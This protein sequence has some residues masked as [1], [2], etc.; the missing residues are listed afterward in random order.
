MGSGCGLQMQINRHLLTVIG[1]KE[2][3]LDQF[4]DVLPGRAP[5]G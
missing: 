3:R 1:P 5:S 4:E 2:G